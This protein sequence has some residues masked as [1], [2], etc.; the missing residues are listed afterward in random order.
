M[1]IWRDIKNYEN[2]YKVSNTGKIFSLKSNKIL[3]TKCSNTKAYLTVKL[4]NDI[5]KVTT[6]RVH[7]IVA[8]TFLKNPKHKSQVN[9]IDMNRHNNNIKNLEWVTAKE[10]TKHALKNK[11]FM[12]DGLKN[13]NKFIKPNK[14]EQ[15]D[16]NENFLACYANSKIAE[17]FTGVCSRN[18]L[19]VANKEEY[20]NGK[21]RKQAG[22]YIWKVKND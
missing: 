2:L 20:K 12:L 3:S 22:G 21:I 8:E 14:I 7:R 1:E 10:N 4:T 19:Q 18:I 15:Y 17:L 5:G 6:Y 9:H 11:P 16:L 13:Y